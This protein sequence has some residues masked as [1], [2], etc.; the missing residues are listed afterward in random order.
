[1]LSQHLVTIALGSGFDEATML[2]EVRT[3]HCFKDLSDAEWTWVM[4]FISRGGQALQGYPQYHKVL[5]VAGI[6]RVMNE[7]VR[8]RHRMSIGTIN[9]DTQMSVTFLGGKRLGS[10]EES[11][12]ARLNAGDCFQFAGRLLELVR[13]RDMTAYVK[14]ATRKSGAVPRWWGTQLPL[15]TE[16]ADSVQEILYLWQQ[17][18]FT[19]PELQSIEAILRLQEQWSHLPGPEDFLI[20]RVQTREGHSLFFFPFAGRLAHE[21]LAMVI[22]KRLSRL[23]PS[24][25]T[26]QINDYGFELQS[27]VPV[28]IELDTLRQV[29]TVEHLLEDI[30]DS[31][32][33]GE[34]AKRRFRDIARIAG[35]VFEGYPG[36]SKSARQ[37][38]ASSGLIFDVLQNYDKDNLLLDQ[39]RREVLEQQLEFERLRDALL[40][41]EKRRWRLQDPGRL[42]P[43]SFPLWAESL[44]SQTI[45]SQ[46]FQQR[47]QSMLDSLEQAAAV[48]LSAP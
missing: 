6:H 22:A 16:L 35:L 31:I 1:V 33:A 20:E 18:R 2:A 8:Q 30:L 36:R 19:S 37:V 43:L 46:S 41:L 13:I 10:T 45:S 17:D 47:V 7:Q 12:I 5:Q 26:L 21:G 44:N 14:A 29:F 24:T 39:A 27:P 48:T 42:T 23:T 28:V 4:D 34:I 11:F 25:F 32:N 40:S 3:T 9:S 15:T 38:Q